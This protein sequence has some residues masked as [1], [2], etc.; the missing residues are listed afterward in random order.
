MN[1]KRYIRDFFIFL[2][3]EQACN[4]LDSLPLESFPNKAAYHLT[5]FVLCLSL[6]GACVKLYQIA[7]QTLRDAKMD[8]EL[9]VLQQQQHLQEEQTAAIA[10]RQ[11]ETVSIQ[12]TMNENLQHFHRLLEEK[13]YENAGAYLH[14]ITNTF[15]QKRF[16]PVCSNSLVSAILD[17]KRET[18]AK[19]Q[20]K[21]DYEILLPETDWIGPADLSSV[22]FNLLDN[23]IEGCIR[24]GC[25]QP[26]IHLSVSTAADFLTI[27]MTNSKNPEEHFDHRTSKKDTFAHG[28]GLSII[29]DICRRNDGSYEWTDNGNTFDSVVL[30]RHGS[31]PSTENIRHA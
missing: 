31:Y 3:L 29:E 4:F 6:A 30:L 2:F 1:T 8:A 20:I 12:Q 14:E 9:T 11:Q 25:P 23:G 7:W 16:R 21:T 28:L 27:R 13:D 10:K 19:Y 18:A 17:S 26:F 22:F 24:S 5:L 15:Q